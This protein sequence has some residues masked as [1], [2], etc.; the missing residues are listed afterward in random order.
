MNFTTIQP[1]PGKTK[2]PHVHWSSF[3]HESCADDDVVT[4]E[5]F[6]TLKP[7]IS[8]HKYTTDECSGHFDAISCFR[9]EIFVFKK[10]VS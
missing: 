5:S 6:T 2:K 10:S 7:D 1:Q 3:S 9:G 4:P 8:T